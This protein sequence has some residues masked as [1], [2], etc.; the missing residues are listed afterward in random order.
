[1]ESYHTPVLLAESLELL[2]IQP[3][4]TYADLTFG[5]GGHSHAILE[6]LSEEG[7]LLGF[8]QDADA[9]KNV[10][11]DPRFRFVEGNFRFMRGLLRAVYTAM[12]WDYWKKQLDNVIL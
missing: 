8:D 12:R 9:K 6:R 1:M 10:P 5:G 3:S 4:G 2:D 11:D 7:R